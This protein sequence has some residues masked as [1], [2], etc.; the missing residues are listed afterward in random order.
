M[1][2]STVIC[3]RLYFISSY[4]KLDEDILQSDLDI[5]NLWAEKNN[6]TINSFKSKTLRSEGAVTRVKRITV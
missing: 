2:K 3:R 4:S 6:M 1:F 5:L